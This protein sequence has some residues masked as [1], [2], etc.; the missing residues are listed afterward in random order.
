MNAALGSL[1]LFLR[2]D[3][4]TGEQMTK[5]TRDA[6][7]I[8]NVPVNDTSIAIAS[9]AA[10]AR[11]LIRNMAFVDKAALPPLRMALLALSDALAAQAALLPEHA[12]ATGPERDEHRMQPYWNR[13]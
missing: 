4:Q 2:T 7:V 6:S 11:T 12:P 8:P 3:V 13:D 1:I 9:M 10:S 5:L